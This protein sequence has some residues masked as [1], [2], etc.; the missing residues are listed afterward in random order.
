MIIPQTLRSITTSALK[1]V[2]VAGLLVAALAT[3]IA[4]PEAR[5]MTDAQAGLP[6]ALLR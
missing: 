6:I 2:F 4:P 5:S 3:A 1:L